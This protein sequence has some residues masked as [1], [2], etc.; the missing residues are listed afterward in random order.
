MPDGFI[1]TYLLFLAKA[2]TIV[3]AIG[4]LVALIVSAARQLGAMRGHERLDVS[5][6]NDRFHD[7]GDTVRDAVSSEAERKKLHKQRRAEDKARRKGRSDEAARRRIYVVNFH[8]D[9]HANAVDNLREEVS[10]VLQVA[11]PGDE[12]LLRLESEGGVV[13]GYGLAASQLARIRSRDI[14]LTVA[15]DKVAA[16]GGYMMACV[17]NKI[18]AAPFAIVGS[19]GVVGQLPNFNRLLK[20]LD[21]DYEQHT[22]GQFKRTLTLFGENTEAARQKFREELEETHGLFRDFV[23]EHRPQLDLERVATGE[24]WFGRQA[25][26]LKLVDELKTSDDYLLEHCEQ[27]DLIKLEFHQHKSLSDR[28]S[29]GFARLGLNLRR[30]LQD[31]AARRWD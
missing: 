30:G 15:V 13:H 8:G 14:A 23:A 12:V 31:T 20:R 22:A 18:I 26:E 4:A 3:V 16:S 11:A 24:H 7:L 9:L 25:L 10:A 2:V 1:E 28:L 5:N 27:A 19:I 6:L 17:A 21:V 29:R